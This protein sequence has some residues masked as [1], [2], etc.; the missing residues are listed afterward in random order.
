[1]KTYE[2]LQDTLA[3]YSVVCNEPYYVSSSVP[4]FEYPDT[5]F[6]MDYYTFCICTA[7]EID[8]EIDNKGYTIGVDTFFVSAPSTV[9]R[10]RRT[11]KDFVM[12]LL[13]FEKTFLLKN[14]SNPFI[15]EK[16]SL[17]RMRTYSIEKVDPGAA[18]TLL[19]LLDYL[20]EKSKSHGRFNE[21]IVRTIVFNILLETAEIIANFPHHQ[22]SD[23][24]DL[25]LRF[26]HLV[27]EN[28]LQQK[29]IQYYAERLYISN[30]YLV[31][32]VRKSSGKTPHEII[33]ESLL[34][35]AYVLLGRP[36]VTISEIAYKLGFSSVSA[37][38]R[39]FKRY[40]SVAPSEYRLREFI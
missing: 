13:F 20:K 21:E 24:K 16:M 23:K 30:K 3:Y 1:M 26:N 12:K 6:R 32:V 33:D 5:P 9:V 15:V 17:F 38:G 18:V 37:F 7:G 25:F 4:I 2:N 22:K 34:K 8:L 31:E 40:A 14:I 29:S 19:R 27:Q 11:S 35:E 28:F 39:F 36:E 10:F